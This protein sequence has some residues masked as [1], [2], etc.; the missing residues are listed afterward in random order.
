MSRK[1]LTPIGILSRTTNPSAGTS[2]DT[3]YNS[4]DGKI[5]VYNGSAW[6]PV[7][8]YTVSDTPPSNAVAGDRWVNSTNGLEYTYVYDGNSYQW[9]NWK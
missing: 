8:A 6:T 4:S 2:G 3:Y 1:Y 7:S 5:Y 9:V